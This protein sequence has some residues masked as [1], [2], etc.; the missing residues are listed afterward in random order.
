ME[1]TTFT[2]SK[3]K[4]QV[5]HI[6]SKL[7]QYGIKQFM[8]HYFDCQNEEKQSILVEKI[9]NGIILTNDKLS[10]LYQTITTYNDNSNSKYQLSVFNTNDLMCYIFHFLD[11]GPNFDGDLFNCS[12]VCSYWLY[13]VWNPNSLYFVNLD[14]LFK[15]FHKNIASQRQWQR[16]ISARMVTLNLSDNSWYTNLNDKMLSR[17]LMFT[18]IVKLHDCS[19][20]ISNFVV[21]KATM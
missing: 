21:L 10:Q 20:Y 2:N 17:L 13:H 7:V 4:Q 11:H 12:L 15:N 3:E 16:I 18:K 5:F 8:G 14:K 6:L 1:T 19:L 9:F